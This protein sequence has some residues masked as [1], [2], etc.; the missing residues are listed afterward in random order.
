MSP[1]LDLDQKKAFINSLCDLEIPTTIRFSPNAQYVLYSTNLTWSHRKGKHAVSTLWLAETGKPNSARQITSGQYKDHSPRWSADGK[2]I[3]FVS[4]RAKAGEKWAIYKLNL[5]HSATEGEA[6]PLTDVENERAIS[7]F[8]F[9]PDGKTIAFVSADE[10]TKEQKRREEDGDDFQIWGEEL[11][12]ARLRTV[13][14]ESK[15]VRCFTA[16]IPKCHVTG[17]SWSQDGKEIAFASTTSPDIEE[18]FLR[19]SRINVLTVRNPKICHLSTFPNYVKDLVWASDGKIYFIS[20][21]P[22]TVACAGSSVYAVSS[23]RNSSSGGDPQKQRWH[24][25]AFGHDDTPTE[26][27]KVGG[28][29]LVKVQR[30]ME[31]QLYLLPSQCLVHTKSEELQAFAAIYP[32]DSDEL[33][34]T[35]A[36]SNVNRP[37]EVYSTTALGGS[38]IQLSSHGATFSQQTFGSCEFISCKSSDGEVDLDGVFLKPSA[39]SDTASVSSPTIVLI[40]GG[41]TARNTNAFNAYYYFWTPYLLRLGYSIL[42]PNYRGSTGRGEDFASYSVRGVGKWDY[43]DVITLTDHAVQLGY[44]NPSRLIV[45]GLSQGGFLS[46]LCSTRNGSLRPWKF[47]AS[48]PLAGITET[49]AMALTSDLGGSLETELSGGKAIWASHKDDTERRRGSA[50]WEVKAAVD[51]SKKTGEMVIPPMLILH[52]DKDERVHISQ[53]W[54]MRRALEAH[55]LKYT[56][57]TYPRQ[58]HVFAERK[59]WVDLA[60]RIGDWCEKYIGPGVAVKGSA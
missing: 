41:P 6:F 53:A 33:I 49:D 35:T 46:Y 59:F 36:T 28:E 30:N 60:L 31:D 15:Q 14:V 12:F 4:D 52:G 7:Q 18:S 27:L 34:I 57:V 9:S 55:G 38:S 24:R 50:L 48:I 39:D 21:T 54:G 20:G 5:R 10:K 3:A 13:D 58:G 42:L 47:A 19:G 25:V 29:V 26:L 16:D 37:I 56:F 1:G 2:S 11:P 8:E 40:H 17:F 32:S 22:V 43:E 51:L 45:G 44:S 23:E